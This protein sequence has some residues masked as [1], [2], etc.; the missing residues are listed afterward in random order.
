M[1]SP[2]PAAAAFAGRY[3]VQE[4]VGYAPVSG[5]LPAARA[6]LD[7]KVVIATGS[8]DFD[9]RQCTPKGGFRVRWV[10]TAPLIKK[11]FGVTR[12]EVGV[13]RR[14][15]MLQ[16]ENCEPV[17]RFDAYQVVLQSRGVVVR[18][19]RDYMFLLCCV[20]LSFFY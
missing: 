7:Q 4:I 3:K 1:A 12:E 17:F 13:P 20:R 6:L 2:T 10:L 18:A 19:G 8:L 9:G 5:G 14:A 11:Y 16:S 15:L